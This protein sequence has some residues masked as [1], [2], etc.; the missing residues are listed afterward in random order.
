VRPDS[1]DNASALNAYIAV[2]SCG[3]QADTEHPATEEGEE[4]AETQSKTEHLSPLIDAAHA[5]WDT[6]PDELMGQ[7]GYVRDRVKVGDPTEA[8]RALDQMIADVDVRCRTVNRLTVQPD[9]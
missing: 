4:A 9:Q 8:L 3:W 6:W 7:A 5:G 1:A 2:C